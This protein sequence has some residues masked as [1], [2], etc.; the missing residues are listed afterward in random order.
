MRVVR[1]REGNQKNYLKGEMPKSQILRQKQV[2]AT[3]T[4]LEM[5]ENKTLTKNI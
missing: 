4:L 1:N 5:A 3:F 2:L